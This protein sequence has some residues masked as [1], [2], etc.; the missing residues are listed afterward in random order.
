MINQDAAIIQGRSAR[1]LTVS[2][3]A[4]TIGPFRETGIY[5]IWCDVDVWIRVAKDGSVS[6]SDAASVTTTNGYKINAGNTVPVQVNAGDI[7]GAIAGGA[8]TLNV[9]QTG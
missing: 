7:V 6:P 4:A 1:Q 9:H 3:T 2:A 5:D 8:G